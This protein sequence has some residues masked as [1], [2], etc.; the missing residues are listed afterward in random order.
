MAAPSITILNFF[1]SVRLH[2]TPSVSNY[3]SLWLFFV[4]LFCY[5]SKYIY[6]HSK[7]N[8]PKKV[9]TTYNLE[10]R[11]YFLFSI[12]YFI[13]FFPV[14]KSVQRG[15]PV[16][17]KIIISKKKWSGVHMYR[18]V[19][20]HA[21]FVWDRRYNFVT[22]NISSVHFYFPLYFNFGTWHNAYLAL[23]LKL[24]YRYMCF[25]NLGLV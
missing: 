15:L 4:H 9:K 21:W 10:R 1:P 14:L 13:P 6:M 12:L 11:K 18:F 2:S 23:S 25:A 20:D 5:V 24:Y 8:I 22:E 3:K 16:E 17:V 7:I 19:W